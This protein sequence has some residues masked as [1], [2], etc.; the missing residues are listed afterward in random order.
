MS[1]A[2]EWIL[3]KALRDELERNWS[4][5]HDIIDENQYPGTRASPHLTS[6]IES[7]LKKEDKKMKARLCPNGN[8]DKLKKTVR[9]DSATAQFDIIRLLLSLATSF[10]SV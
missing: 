8:R 5:T 6:F 9:K 2:T 1:C 10:H 7:K 3:E 4:D